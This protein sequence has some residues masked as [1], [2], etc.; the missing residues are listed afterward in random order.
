MKALTIV[1]S[2]ML[3]AA[4]LTTAV[5]AMS[6]DA[7][8]NAASAAMLRPGGLAVTPNL[9]IYGHRPPMPQRGTKVT[10]PDRPPVTAQISPGLPDQAKDDNERGH[11][12]PKGRSLRAFQRT[13]GTFFRQ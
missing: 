3:G 11:G 7:T 1:A 5:T 4:C 9:R 6:A 8:N 12:A 13:D 2:V 10:P